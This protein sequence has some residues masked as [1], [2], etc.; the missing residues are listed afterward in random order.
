MAR[1]WSSNW[2]ALL[3]QLEERIGSGHRFSLVVALG[4]LHLSDRLNELPRL[5]SPITVGRSGALCST[6]SSQSG[7]AKSLGNNLREFVRLRRW[8]LEAIITDILAWSKIRN[9]DAGLNQYRLP[10]IIM[11]AAVL[12]LLIRSAVGRFGN[13]RSHRR[14]RG[15]GPLRFTTIHHLSAQF[16]DFFATLVSLYFLVNSRVQKTHHKDP[17][18]QRTT[19]IAKPLC[20]Q[21]VLDIP[22]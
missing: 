2:R 17:R 3:S 16:L 22:C 1:F 8:L 11:V 7:K 6:R 21:S 20:P 5:A 15:G 18:S 10:A 9:V 4:R 14:L 12:I 13:G 19:E